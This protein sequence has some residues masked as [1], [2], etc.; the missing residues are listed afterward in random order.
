MNAPDGAPRNSDILPT[1]VPIEIGT[2]AG[3]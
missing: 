3:K 1:V 2:M